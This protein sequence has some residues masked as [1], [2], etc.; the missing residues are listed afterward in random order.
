MERRRRRTREDQKLRSDSGVSNGES[1]P[2]LKYKVLTRGLRLHNGSF[3]REMAAISRGNCG[4]PGNLDIKSCE[5]SG[6]GCKGETAKQTAKMK[7]EKTRER[8][9]INKKGGRGSDRG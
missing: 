4:T 5:F 3:A 8:K 2:S 1:N 9:N 7:R 6:T